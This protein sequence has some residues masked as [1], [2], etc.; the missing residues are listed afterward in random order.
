M[1]RKSPGRAAIAGRLLAG[2]RLDGADAGIEHASLIV[3]GQLIGSLVQ[4]A[5][6]ANLVPGL[7]EALHHF[8]IGLK[9]P[10]RDE[11]GLSE[12]EVPP[13]LDQPG[14]GDSRP[15]A[16]GGREVDA[17]RSILG[18]I[19]VEQALSIEVEGEADGAAGAIGP[20]R[21]IVDQLKSHA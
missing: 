7:H 10:P 13:D 18:I 16:Q 2:Q 11:Q 8:R 1:L 21:W 15:V 5:V 17:A 14:N 4:I 3:A 19:Q 12:V 20:G 9:T 6:M